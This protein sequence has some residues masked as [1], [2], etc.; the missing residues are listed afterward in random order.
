MVASPVDRTA[1]ID[2]AVVL[3][4]TRIFHRAGDPAPA[5]PHTMVG[6]LTMFQRTVLTLRRGGITRILVLAGAE[7]EAL[8]QQLAD[9]RNHKPPSTMMVRW[10]PISEFPPGDPTTWETLS[11][12][13]GHFLV[14]GAGA[15]FSDGLVSRLREHANHEPAVIVGKELDVT[16]GVGEAPGVG[17]PP[18]DNGAVLTLERP[19]ATALALDLV[20][21]APRGN[22]PGWAQ[23]GPYPLQAA[24]SRGLRQGDVKILALES[25]RYQEVWSDSPASVEQAEWVLLKDRFEGFIGRHFN[26]P[27]PEWLTRV[28]RRIIHLSR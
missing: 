27:C 17:P 12:M 2:S 23:D 1:S 16:V 26:R 19:V 11:G 18:T 5:A 24:F 15:I 6:G 13:I 28:L 14:A 10:L 7:T 22:F 4:V 8:K 9:I 21:F 25:D 20:A 3:P